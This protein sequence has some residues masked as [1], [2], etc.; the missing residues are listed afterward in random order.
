MQTDGAIDGKAAGSRK[1][2]CRHSAALLHFHDDGP[3]EVVHVMQLQSKSRT[4]K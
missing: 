1:N 4:L 3:H 2:M